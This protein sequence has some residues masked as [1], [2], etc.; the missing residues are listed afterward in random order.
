M[1]HS[2]VPFPGF[3]CMG[4]EP[5][6]LCCI[7]RKPQAEANGSL[8]DPASGQTSRSRSVDF[9]AQQSR[10]SVNPRAA[11]LNS[12][13]IHQQGEELHNAVRSPAIVEAV[14][15]L[16][17]QMKSDR[18]YQ[19]REQFAACALQRSASQRR[20]AHPSDKFAA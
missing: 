5:E 1:F 18:H 16:S 4:S 15:P 3:L 6:I 13:S 2:R 11:K 10:R 17:S 20:L 14:Q 7:L 12:G 19:A 8:N 9:K